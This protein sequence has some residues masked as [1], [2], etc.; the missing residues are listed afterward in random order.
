MKSSIH[1]ANER[2]QI[3]EHFLEFARQLERRQNF[4]IDLLCQCEPYDTA[5]DEFGKS[6]RALK[7]FE[8][9]LPFLENR[10]P[11]G[12]VSVLLPFNNPLYSLILYTFGPC[13]G[14]ANVFVRPSSHTRNIIVA[15]AEAFSNN[16]NQ[17]NINIMNLSGGELIRTIEHNQDIRTVI[18]TGSWSSMQALAARFSQKRLIYCGS[19]ISPFIAD[20]FATRQMNI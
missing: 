12:D 19:G 13:L 16:L 11:I 9:E 10:A 18:F 3:I 5:K 8:T 6:I 17:L 4:V 2:S 15:L 1:L 20:E 7:T 14:G